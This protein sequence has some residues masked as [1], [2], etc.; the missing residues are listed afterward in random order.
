MVKDVDGNSL[1]QCATKKDF[2]V[3]S[4]PYYWGNCGPGCPGSPERVI[5][6]RTGIRIFLK[7]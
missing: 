4:K 7:L 3:N 5:T 2:I 1:P 6:G